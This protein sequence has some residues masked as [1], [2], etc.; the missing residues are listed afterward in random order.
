MR[1]FFISR[2]LTRDIALETSARIPAL[3]PLYPTYLLN[4]PTK[5]TKMLTFKPEFEIY[6]ISSNLNSP[7]E[8]W[9]QSINR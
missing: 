5:W 4:F 8:Q 3:S 9:H 7:L 1:Y 2:F 6:N